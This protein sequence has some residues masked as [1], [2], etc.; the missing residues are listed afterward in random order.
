MKF[1]NSHSVY[2][3]RKIKQIHCGSHKQASYWLGAMMSFMV[4]QVLILFMW[5]IDLWGSAEGVTDTTQK[6][7]FEAE[8]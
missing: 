6:T 1:F 5:S 7:L 4:V 8:T 3:S 2:F